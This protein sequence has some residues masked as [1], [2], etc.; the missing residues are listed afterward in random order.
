MSCILRIQDVELKI[1]AV[2]E[3]KRP[4]GND[5]QL[6]SMPEPEHQ[7]EPVVRNGEHIKKQPRNI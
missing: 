7:A 6:P 5:N 1:L 2:L 4:G 3:G